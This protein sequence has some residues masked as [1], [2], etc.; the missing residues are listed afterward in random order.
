MGQNVI[1]PGKYS[2]VFTKR[3][4]ANS[5]NF[6]QSRRISCSHAPGRRYGKEG[7]LAFAKLRRGR[8]ARG[9]NA[10]PNESRRNQSRQTPLSV[11]GDRSPSTER[12]PSEHSGKLPLRSGERLPHILRGL[13]GLEIRRTGAQFTTG[14]VRSHRTCPASRPR[15]SRDQGAGKDASAL[16]SRAQRSEVEGSR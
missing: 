13:S 1:S 16:S 14:F 2:A 6:P 12:L 11:C 8:Q 5:L 4:C 15:S 3:I 9:Y 10:D 7:R